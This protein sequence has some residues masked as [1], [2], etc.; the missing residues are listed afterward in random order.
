V[1]AERGLEPVLG[2]GHPAE[3]SRGSDV[4]PALWL[5]NLVPGRNAWDHRCR[6]APMATAVVRAPQPILR[7][8][9]VLTKAERLG[10]GLYP[11]VLLNFNRQAVSDLFVPDCGPGDVH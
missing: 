4:L 8:Y 3:Q 9:P 6:R 5:Q 11:G 2:P 10:P 1:T 7:H